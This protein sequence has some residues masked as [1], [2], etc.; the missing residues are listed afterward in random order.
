MDSIYGANEA[1]VSSGE[2]KEKREDL[3]KTII[4][5]LENSFRVSLRFSERWR[6]LA[7]FSDKCD[8]FSERSHVAD[9]AATVL[10]RLAK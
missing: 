4:P 3:F 5:C 1:Q 6:T 10:E 8:G 2:K 9:S 7:S